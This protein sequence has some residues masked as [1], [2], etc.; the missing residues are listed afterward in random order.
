MAMAMDMV[1]DPVGQALTLAARRH[2]ARTASLLVE[3]GLFPGQDRV[4][5]SLAEHDS[6][7]MTAIADELRVKPPTA[8][9]MISRMAAQGLL[10]RKG[11]EDDARLVVV[12]ITSEGLARIE[13]L[14]KIARRME[15]DALA[16]LDDKDV[17]RLRRLLKKVARNLGDDAAPIEAEDQDPDV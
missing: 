10:E 14:R 3:L 11:K 2:R 17:R 4:L 16:G 6:L 5:Q 8:S 12:S 9:K 13:Q 7:T 15:K 1:I